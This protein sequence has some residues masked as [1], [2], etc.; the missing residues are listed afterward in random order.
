[1]V[2]FESLGNKKVILGLVHLLP[3]PGTPFYEEGNAERSLDKAV[4]DAVALYEGGADGC[5]VQTVDR[6][7]PV[8][9]EVD[10]ARLAAMSVI[11][12]AVSE[13]TGPDFQVGVQIMWNALKASLAVAHVCGGSFLRC[14]AFVGST[15]TP[16][17]IAEADP[18]GFH[19]YRR[20]IGANDISLI[21]EVDSMHFQWLHG[22][23]TAAEV[24]DLA[25]R[26]G[27]HAVEVAQ[28][29]EAAN[30]QLIDQLKEA[31][32]ELPIILGG[33]TNHENAARRLAHADGAFVGSCFQT[34]GWGSHIDKDLVRS[35]MEIVGQIS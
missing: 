31:H 22:E 21:A 15:M 5:L 25:V 8:G 1:M 23:Q 7:Y 20:Q 30:A 16:A 17:G 35:Y 11:V 3:L 4:A 27:A 32:P 12:N 19:A 9:E 18:I 24:A 28:A 34:G 10:Y 13:A 29:D 33:F 14:T 26:A 2:K 6:V